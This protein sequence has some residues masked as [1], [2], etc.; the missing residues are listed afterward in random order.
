LNPLRHTTLL[1]LSSLILAACTQTPTSVTTLIDPDPKPIETTDPAKKIGFRVTSQRFDGIS[2]AWDTLETAAILERKSADG[3]SVLLGTFAVGAGSFRDQ[4]LPENTPFTYEFR[5]TNGS[6]VGTIVTKTI[7]VKPG[8]FGVSILEPRDGLKTNG[9]V[10]VKLHVVGEPNCV[11]LQVPESVSSSRWIELPTSHEITLNLAGWFS[12]AAT[13]VIKAKPCQQFTAEVFDQVQVLFDASKPSMWS[14]NEIATADANRLEVDF[15]KVMPDQDWAS[16][17]TLSGQN[18]FPIRASFRTETY[19]QKGYSSGPD[20]TAT[21]LIVVPNL[22]LAFNQKYTLGVQNVVDEYGNIMDEIS[23]FP[24]RIS[25]YV[26]ETQPSQLTK[27]ELIP[28]KDYSSD[29]YINPFSRSANDPLDAFAVFK[30]QNYPVSVLPYKHSGSS[31]VTPQAISGQLGCQ[32]AQWY[33]SNQYKFSR[34]GFAYFSCEITESD[35]RKLVI[36][37]IRDYAIQR[38]A[39][40]PNRVIWLPTSNGK[41]DLAW[42]EAIANGDKQ[43]LFAQFDPITGLGKSS[44]LHTG[45]INR[46][47]QIAESANGHRLICFDLLLQAASGERYSSDT[48]AILVSRFVPGK[49]WRSAETLVKSA[50]LSGYGS[51]SDLKAMDVQ[52]SG[53]ALVHWTNAEPYDSGGSGYTPQLFVFNGTSWTDIALP[54]SAE[55]QDH[56]GTLKHVVAKDGRM[57][58]AWTVR[59]YGFEHDK[60]LAAVWFDPKTN[61]WGAIKRFTGLYQRRSSTSSNIIALLDSTDHARVLSFDEIGHFLLAR[62][63]DGGWDEPKIV[64]PNLKFFGTTVQATIRDDDKIFVTATQVQIANAQENL[65]E[66]STWAGLIP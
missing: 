32:G 48:D 47:R 51:R 5:A 25:F 34:D 26:R 54:M 7:E 20:K 29:V 2:I 59:A 60:E 52:D 39:A 38:V 3:P 58:F 64:A 46:V 23:Y 45:K 19:I 44:I 33:E 21:R 24:N 11:R 53:Q 4:A 15:T 28:P 10:K 22:P 62:E 41:I 66:P 1:I 65:L 13:V 49:G 17:V 57:F 56:I 9:P 31:S 30:Y 14:R 27:L 40:F 18:H 55:F 37:T 8:Q 42:S 16:L 12:Q 36:Y 61:Q 43:L 35:G 63:R 6:S 50:T